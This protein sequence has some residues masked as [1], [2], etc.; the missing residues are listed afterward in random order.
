MKEIELPLVEE[1]ST[2]IIDAMSLMKAEW[3]C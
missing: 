3:Q 1:K 2:F